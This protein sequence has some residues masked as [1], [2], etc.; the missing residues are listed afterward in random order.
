[1]HRTQE[2]LAGEPL[3]IMLGDRP[4]LKGEVVCI[5]E[6]YGIRLTEIVLPQEMGKFRH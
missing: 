2:K 1:M 5:N 4:V 6:K 3:E